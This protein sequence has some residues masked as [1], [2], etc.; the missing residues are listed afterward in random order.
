MD[1]RKQKQKR[2]RVLFRIY[3]VLL[4]IFLYAPVAVM[5]AFSFNNSRANVVWSGFTTDYYAKL[6]RDADMWEVFLDTIIVSVTSTALGAFLGT[7]GAVGLRK[8]GF[9]GKKI[10]STSIYFPIVIPEIVLAVAL[11][12][13]FNLLDLP[14]SIGT[15]IIGNT[16]L[17]LP[18]VFINVRSRLAGMDPAMEEASM[19]LG[20]DRLYTFLHVTLPAILPGVGAGAFMAFSLTLDELIITSFL[21]DA[22]TITLP[23]RAFTMI[24]KGISPEINALTTI[25][26]LASFLIILIYLLVNKALEKR[27]ET[28]EMGKKKDLRVRWIALACTAV[29]AV[30]GV[31]GAVYLSGSSSK[32]GPVGGT[33]SGNT[34]TGA[35]LAETTGTDTLNLLVWSGFWSEEVFR[36]FEKETGIKVNVSY[37]DNTDVLMAK[38]LEGSADYDIIDLETG[39]ADSFIRNGLLAKINKD[40]IPNLHNIEDKY[41]TEN[42]A[43]IGDAEEEYVVPDMAPL[44]TTIIYNKETCP[45]K[46]TRLS[47]LADPRLKGQVALVNSTISLYGG[48]LAD[49]G[50]SPDST[51]PQEMKE[52]NDLLMKIKPNVK[53]FVGESAVSQLESGE[54]S[55]AYCWDYNILCN[56]SREN[57]DKFEF[58]QLPCGIENAPQ[59]WAIPSSSTKKEAAE[60]FIDFECRPE[61]NAKNLR[62]FGG[63]P[64]IKRELIGQYLP[65]DYYDSPLTEV[66]EVT[67]NNSWKIAVRDEQQAIMDVYYTELMSGVE[68]ADE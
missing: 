35:T 47:D 59:Y 38:L 9:K 11:L 14:L 41:F 36:D 45:I 55:V 31:A 3:T 43:P 57:W 7:T 15:V 63:V 33:A 29:L 20:A 2:D 40:N 54:C 67:F 42:G 50:Y 68:T 49:L 19:D 37:I 48:A 56:D 28:E 25:I 22:Q 58:V 39:Y 53:A 61:E 16:T 27:A 62:E 18:Y 5:V 12:I 4:F 10:F 26:L 64:I 66:Y 8:A 32:K 34:E 60:A 17:V 30:T 44:Y 23:L 46:P 13:V 21:A 1:K 65:D 51:D 6:F 52:A 24:K